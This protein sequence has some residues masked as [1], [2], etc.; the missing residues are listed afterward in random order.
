MKKL[1]IIL[2]SIIMLTGCTSQIEG[3][4]RLPNSNLIIS[5]SSGINTVDESIKGGLKPDI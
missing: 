4:K 1:V 3:N 2:I 5:Y